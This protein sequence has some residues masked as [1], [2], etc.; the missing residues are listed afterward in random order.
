MATK[1]SWLDKVA[2]WLLSDRAAIKSNE[3]KKDIDGN[4]EGIKGNAS[5]KEESVKEIDNLIFDYQPNTKPSVDNIIVEKLSLFV[6]KKQLLKETALKLLPKSRYGLI[7][8]NGSGKSSLLKIIP[9]L[10][11]SKNLK[12]T[13]NY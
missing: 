5:I 9:F 10:P 6:S 13:Q 8:H 2:R 3:I 11:I 7:G 4:T 1:R 12:I